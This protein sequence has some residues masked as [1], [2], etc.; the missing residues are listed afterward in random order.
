MK[1][2]QKNASDVEAVKQTIVKERLA[3]GDA[4]AVKQTIVKERLFAGDTEA[5]KQ[6]IVKERLADAVETKAQS[7]EII[8]KKAAGSAG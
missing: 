7:Q 5:V 2:Q 1:H 3:A 6:T 4:E 8:R